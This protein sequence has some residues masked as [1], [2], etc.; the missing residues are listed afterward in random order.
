[1]LDGFPCQNKANF[2]FL[3]AGTCGAPLPGCLR[4]PRRPYFNQHVSSSPSLPHTRPRQ[5]SYVLNY[6]TSIRSSPNKTAVSD[7]FSLFSH[8]ALIFM[9]VGYSVPC[10][11]P[12][13]TYRCPVRIFDGNYFLFDSDSEGVVPN[14]K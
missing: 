13:Y 4:S 5:D 8:L 7:R 3:K 2:R 1:M 11:V 9:T 10:T 14:H 12:V 6:R